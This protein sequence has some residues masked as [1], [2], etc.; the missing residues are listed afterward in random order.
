[1]SGKW[2]PVLTPIVGERLE[3]GLS[4][5]FR[6]GST[7]GEPSEDNRSNADI[8]QATRLARMMVTHRG[9]SPELGTV[10]YGENQERV[11]LGIHRSR[12]FWKGTPIRFADR[13]GEPFGNACHSPGPEGSPEEPP[14]S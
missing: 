9:F 14:I 13:V 2:A 7:S 1:M 5:S 8:D 6:A 3:G 11:F 10:A 4:R 12:P